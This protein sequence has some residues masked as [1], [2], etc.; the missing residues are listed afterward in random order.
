[1]EVSV[2]QEAVYE[3]LL[4]L[5][6]CKEKFSVVFSGKGRR[7]INGLY[8][9]SRKEILI[10]NLNFIDDDNECNENQLIYTAIHELAHHIQATE[11]GERG[12]RCHTQLFWS[13]FHDLLAKA[14]SEG[15][16][17]LELDPET[18]ALADQARE[19]SRQIAKTQRDLGETLERLDALCRK[20]GVRTEDVFQRRIQLTPATWRKAI[21]ANNL[22]VEEDDNIGVDQQAALLGARSPEARAAMVEGS[23][24]GKTVEQLKRPAVPPPSGPDDKLE[25]LVRERERLEKNILTMERRLSHVKMLLEDLAR[26]PP[27]EKQK[28]AS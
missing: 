16:Y 11:F 25:E 7:R 8:S 26:G 9:H 13:C 19:L 18:Q 22:G 1:L 24:E 23:R 27:G 15:V 4:R 14:E 28:E 5:W 20:Q 6:K 12:S 3:K 2:N 17:R 10:H 21:A